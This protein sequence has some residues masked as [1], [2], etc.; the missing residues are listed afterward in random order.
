[1][2]EEIEVKKGDTIFLGVAHDEDKIGFRVNSHLFEDYESKRTSTPLLDPDFEHL[3]NKQQQMISEL[4]RQ[5]YSHPETN[6]QAVRAALRVAIDPGCI[7]AHAIDPQ[8]A[9]LYALS[10]FV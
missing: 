7:A 1:M 3:C 6:K 5:L 4:T 2:V 9:L 8:E 10:F